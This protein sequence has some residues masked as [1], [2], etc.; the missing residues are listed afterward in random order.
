VRSA[1]DWLKRTQDPAGHWASVQQ[2][3]IY[4]TAYAVIALMHDPAGPSAELRKAVGYL[5]ARMGPD[6][7]CSD[8]GGTLMCGLALHAVVGQTVGANL[9]MAD[10]VLARKNLARAEA[11]ET[12]LKDKESAL[13]IAEA[14]V[15]RYEKKYGDADIV[16]TKRHLLLLS[17]VALLVTVIGTVAGV[18]GLNAFISSH[19]GVPVPVGT[20]AP[21]SSPTQTDSPPDSLR[22]EAVAASVGPRVDSTSTPARK[23]GSP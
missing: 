17:L 8:L 16:F 2:Y 11:A 6:G 4:F 20:A 9:T 18:Y 7:K 5:K 1:L 22:K 3:E 14:E 10:F 12:A 15:A 23:A 21:S 19:A 13:S